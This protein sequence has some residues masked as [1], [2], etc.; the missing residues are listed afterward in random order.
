MFR[1]V[2]QDCHESQDGDHEAV[3]DWADEHARKEM[4]DVSIERV[5]TDGGQVCLREREYRADG[6]AETTSDDRPD[7]YVA[8]ESEQAKCATCDRDWRG[9]G[10][11]E[12]AAAHAAEYGHR[13]RYVDE[14]VF[15]GP[16][17]A[18]Q[19]GEQDA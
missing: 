11:R 12:V 7:A 14:A 2:C 17:E 18:V 15:D 1:A 8:Y 4:H 6:G 9:G 10:A 5:A 16:E 13:V 19:D 3:A